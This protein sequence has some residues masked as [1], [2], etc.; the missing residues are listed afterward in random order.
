MDCSEFASTK[1][2]DTVSR[3]FYRKFDV[4]GKKKYDYHHQLIAHIAEYL[5][6]H[7]SVKRCIYSGPK[8]I[9]VHERINMN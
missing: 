6:T 5:K 1:S 9:Q 2:G 3:N 7:G 4:K 8:K